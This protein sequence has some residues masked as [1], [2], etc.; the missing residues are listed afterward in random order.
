MTRKGK[1]FTLAELMVVVAIIA[2]L[3]VMIMP[4][5]NGVFR[6]VRERICANNLHQIRVAV[7]SLQA[8]DK[9]ERTGG[10]NVDGWRAQLEAYDDKSKDLM[11]CPEG[12]TVATAWEGDDVLA[13]YALATYS[14]NSF[15]YNMIL[16]PGPAC[17]KENVKGG[18]KTYDL[19]FEDQRS[20]T[21]GATGDLSY[22]NPVITIEILGQDVKVTVKGGAGGYHWH[23][24]DTTN[25]KEY[26]HD[27]LK[28]PGAMPGDSVVLPGAIGLG[29]KFSYGLNS[30]APEI[31]RTDRRILALD[32]PE[33]VA[34]IAGLNEI[35]D[36]WMKWTNPD[37]QFTFARH[38]G[39]CNVV[40]YD[41]SVVQMRPDEINPA[42]QEIKDK[43]WK[44]RIVRPD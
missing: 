44:P 10:L 2:L 1:G 14:G 21:G 16:A 42:V 11:I 4:M 15:K 39:R 33:E 19:S 13:R 27:I 40:M 8:S 29:G 18:G 3:V 22:N 43:Y 37:G 7:A 20:S 34:R 26:L 30:V 31:E 41:G 12:Y 17:R 9:M 25:N 23:L 32:Y 24:I 38:G 36:N 28:A 6:I 5:L 35:H